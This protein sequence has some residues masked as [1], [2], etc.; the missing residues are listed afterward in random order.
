[1]TPTDGASLFYTTHDPHTLQHLRQYVL[2][3]LFIPPAPSPGAVPGD[4]SAPTPYRNPFPFNEKP[5]ILDRDHILV[6]SGWDSWGKIAVLRD[7]FEAKPWGEAW[8][9]DLEAASDSNQVEDETEKGIKAL[10][11]EL[12]PDQS[13]KVSLAVIL[14]K[15]VSY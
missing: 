8:D 14:A 13:I 7:G 6:P 12:V 11:A 9:Y 3:T 4:S 5:N 1:M 2:H 15:S 10:Y